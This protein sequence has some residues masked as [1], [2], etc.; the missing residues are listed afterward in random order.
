M[1]YQH[2]VRAILSRPWAIDPESLAWSAIC[3]VLAI[4]ASGDHLTA[5]EI[6]AGLETAAAANGAR[7]GARTDR[8]VAVIPVYGVLSPRVEAMTSASGGTSAEMVRDSFRAALTNPDIDGIVFDVDSPGGVVEGIDEL[9]AEIRDARGQK[10]IAAVANH[11]AASAA[12]WAVAGVDELVATPS[13]SVGSIGVFTAHQDVSAAMEAKGVRTTL[14]SA[15]KYKVEG[16]QYEPLG[17]EARVDIQA[18]VDSWYDTM[19]HSIAKGRGVGVDVVRDTYGEGRVLRAKRALERGMVDRIDSLDNTI[20]RVARGTVGRDRSKAAAAFTPGI[21]VAS[22]AAGETT[23]DR[24]GAGAATSF[25][26]RA[27]AAAAEVV[28]IGELARKRAELRA[29]EGRAPSPADGAAIAALARSVAELPGV[30][31][32]ETETT[33]TTTTETT[34]TVEEESTST[35]APATPEANRRRRV[36]LELLEAATRGGYA[37]PTS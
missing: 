31:V 24:D 8:N 9:A 10:P 21:R 11:M 18:M 6:R 27:E 15:G 26:A 7:G 1:K 4:R 2:I 19:V 13:A 16:N 3:D 35:E 25:A 20:R 12:Y 29:E 32:E 28:A 34:E 14:I 36:D 30:E 17:E 23:D 22:L 33:E 37:L 5:E